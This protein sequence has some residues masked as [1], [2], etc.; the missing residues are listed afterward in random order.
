MLKFLL[1]IFYN[2]NKI[3]IPS[4]PSLYQRLEMGRV[5]IYI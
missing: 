4:I 3:I 5:F 1:I 2:F